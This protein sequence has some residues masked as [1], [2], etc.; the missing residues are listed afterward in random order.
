MQSSSLGLETSSGYSGMVGIS[1][2]QQMVEAKYP[3]LL[4]KQHIA[5]YVEKTY[6]M[7][8]DSLKKEINPLINLCIHVSTFI[9]ASSYSGTYLS[10]M[11]F[12]YVNNVLYVRCNRHQDR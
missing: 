8:R 2:D 7:I 6:G 9:H 5:A 1:N 4:F 10:D 12:M 3:A 11:M